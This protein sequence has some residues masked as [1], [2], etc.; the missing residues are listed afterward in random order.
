MNNENFMPSFSISETPKKGGSN[1]IKIIAVLIIWGVSGIGICL[2]TRVWD[3]IWSPFRPTP[4]QVLQKM[5]NQM[6]GL[7]TYCDKTIFAV[8]FKNKQ[9]LKID[10]DFAIDNDETN[11]DNPKS[12]AKF[13]L[14]LATEGMQFS[15]A[16]E[17][18][19]IGETIY[20]KLTTIPAL[21][22]LEPFFAIMGI[23][24]QQIK[25][26]WI[27]FDMGE[28][29]KETE[30]QTEKQKELKRNLKELI[31][32]KNFFI[33]K[34]E[35]PDEKI[36]GIKT[37]HYAVALNNEEVKKIIPELLKIAGEEGGTMPLPIDIEES[38]E[39]IDEF[40]NKVGEITAD[41]W[42]GK[43]DLYLYKLELDKEIDLNRFEDNE[44]GTIAIEFTTEFS[45]F[46]QPI[47]TTVP[48]EFKTIKEIFTPKRE[49]LTPEPKFPLDT[50]KNSSFLTASLKEILSKILNK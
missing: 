41:V 20:F 1:F 21:P 38:Q 32:N 48:G 44:K 17:T 22:M 2:A 24:L 11:P 47:E 28:F 19:T 37:Y 26:Q 23:D 39:K 33:V 14:N 43:K 42:I 36:N 27:K 9:E 30:K 46:N 3:P 7:R 18:K 8:N 31:A 50:E 34:A 16:G 45:K 15:L 29:K 10:G 12:A 4:E 13:N 40:L 25:N 35:L 5:M 49:F 6:E